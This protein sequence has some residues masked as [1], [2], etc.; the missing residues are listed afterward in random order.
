MR[1]CVSN[2]RHIHS[3]RKDDEYEIKQKKNGDIFRSNDKEKKKQKRM[4]FL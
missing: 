3:S 4:D 2:V 1:V